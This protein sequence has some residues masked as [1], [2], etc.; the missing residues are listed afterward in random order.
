MDDAL[1]KKRKTRP[2]LTESEEEG[3]P[4]PL[5]MRR[6]RADDSPDRHG[7]PPPAAA[8]K[9]GRHAEG[10]GGKGREGKEGKD[11]S[12]SRNRN[13]EDA[14]AALAYFTEMHKAE[15]VA[16]PEGPTPT[17]SAA[18][19]AYSQE[20]LKR[21]QREEGTRKQ[22][23]P[24]KAAAKGL[25]AQLYEWLVGHDA[26]VAVP[27]KMWESVNDQLA[28]AGLPPMPRFIHLFRNNKDRTILP[29]IVHEAM[30]TVTRED[31][32]DAMRG[33]KKP[34]TVT[35]ALFAAILAKV[36]TSVR[37]YT[38]Q[39]RLTDSLPKGSK[40]TDVPD[41]PDDVATWGVQLH[42][43]EAGARHFQDKRKTEDEKRAANLNKLEPLVN[44]YFA[45]AGL[46]NELGN[47]SQRVVIGGTPY[48]LVR[49]VTSTKAAI[50]FGT[51]DRALWGALHTAWGLDVPPALFGGGGGDEDEEE[52]DEEAAAAGAG[53]RGRK[54]K[55]P[56]PDPLKSAD[57]LEVLL[58]RRRTALT[59]AVTKTLCELPRTNKTEIKLYMVARP[60]IAAPKPKPVPAAG[61]GTA[62]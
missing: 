20:L 43:N 26:L 30:A 17:E 22:T 40:P 50:R 23:A 1:G 44:S 2:V 11:R 48:R 52:D 38:Q 41:A 10:K 35:A 19:F 9:R 57:A 14:K 54:K 42:T 39:V 21:Q 55:A 58:D 27:L 56:L 28:A 36:R 3:A 18:M 6:R 25:R 13:P 32:E 60:R 8:G 47:A 37:E 33:S 45:R 34:L 51:I 46:M 24:M 59:D 12:R 5:V 16:E 4:A 61:P 7:S 49:R 62:A 53:A 15:G 31:V 29:E